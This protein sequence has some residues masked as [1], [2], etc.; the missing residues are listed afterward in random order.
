MARI[1][2][3]A[4]REPVQMGLA[5]KLRVVFFRPGSRVCEAPNLDDPADGTR[6]SCRAGP[7]DRPIESPRRRGIRL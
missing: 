1:G 2:M 5:D 7:S 6:P 4:G 3:L